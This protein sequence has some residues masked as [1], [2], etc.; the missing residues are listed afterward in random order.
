MLAEKDI[1]R[2]KVLAARPRTSLTTTECGE[3]DDLRSAAVKGSAVQMNDPNFGK[4][5]GAM[6]RHLAKRTP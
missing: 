5:A 6:A 4:L 1:A 3:L 2:L